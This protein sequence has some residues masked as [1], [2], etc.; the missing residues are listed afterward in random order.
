MKKRVF[1]IIMVVFLLTLT[2]LSGCSS[3]SSSTP[4][5]KDSGGKTKLTILTTAAPGKEK[6]W[7]FKEVLKPEFEKANPDITLEV[8]AVPW[9]NF[10][11]KLSTLV[12]GGTPPDVFSHWG[13]SGFADYTKR[14]LAADLTPYMDSFENKNI[15]Q[16]LLDIY[17]IG[18]KQMGIPFASFQTYVY[19]NKDLFDKAG[20]PYPEYKFGDPNW[21][22]EELRNI[23]KKLTSNYGKPDAVYGLAGDNGDRD[24]YGWDY[25]VD[26]YDDQAYQTGIVKDSHFDD[27]RYAEAIEYFRANIYDHKISPSPAVTEAIAQTGDAFVTGKVAINVDGGWGLGNYSNNNMNFGIAPVPVGPEGTSTPV[28]YVDP[29]M[30]SAKTKH[31]EE[32]WKLIKFMTSTEI[33]KKFAQEVGHPPADS[34]AFGEWTKRFEKNIDPAYLQELAQGSIENGKES[35][36]HMLAGYGEIRTFFLNETETIFLNNKDPKEILPPLK[37]KFKTLIQNI[38][39]KTAK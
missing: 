2:A 19:Y 7:F 13:A 4:S 30:M 36:N 6:E 27:P 39:A 29:L 26:L 3:S 8:I 20:V 17:K 28:L 38:E 25:G 18:G 12:A 32:A 15:T 33:Q 14:N 31:P 22:W 10:D 1:S 34:E 23:A 35:P 24:N 11:S 21:T 16:N 37:E 9:D 5:E